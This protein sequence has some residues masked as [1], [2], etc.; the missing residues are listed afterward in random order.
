MYVYVST[1][2]FGRRLEGSRSSLCLDV[3]RPLFLSFFFHSSTSCLVF[4]I[5]S[6]EF[7]SR[8]LFDQ[9]FCFHWQRQVSICAV[10]VLSRGQEWFLL[11]AKRSQ[12]EQVLTRMPGTLEKLGRGHLNLPRAQRLPEVRDL[13]I[14]FISSVIICSNMNGISWLLEEGCKIFW[15]N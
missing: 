7:L 13:H 14:F 6:E 11:W 5:E 12:T 2:V 3:S 4:C 10:L 15:T 8:F 9:L 1:S